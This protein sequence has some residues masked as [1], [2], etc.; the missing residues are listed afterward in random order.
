[1]KVA[2]YSP[3]AFDTWCPLGDA[4]GN[5]SSV[6][7]SPV[8]YTGNTAVA[9]LTAGGVVQTT[10]GGTNWNRVA[11]FDGLRVAAL[12]SDFSKTPIDYWAVTATGVNGQPGAAIF[13]FDFLE[14][15]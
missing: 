5:Y 1:M 2:A 10:N 9:G 12:V 13:H 6:A 7:M 4:G 11:G 14:L 8:F 15:N 3:T